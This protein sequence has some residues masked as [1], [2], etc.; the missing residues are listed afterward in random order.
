MFGPVDLLNLLASALVSFI[1]V[2][3]AYRAREQFVK[4]SI[5]VLLYLH[6]LIQ[7][8]FALRQEFVSDLLPFPGEAM[9]LI[10]GIVI[11]GLAV[12]LLT[13]RRIASQIF[14]RVT[15][16][17]IGYIHGAMPYVIVL[18]VLCLSMGMLHI[19]FV[20]PSELGLVVALVEP[21][22]SAIAREE[23]YK[24]VENAALRYGFSLQTSTLAPLCAVLVFGLLESAVRQRRLR[25]AIAWSLVLLT[26]IVLVSL[27][28]ARA[29][30]A[31]LVLSIAASIAL[32]RGL[33]VKPWWA[34]AAVALVLLP[35][36]ALTALRQGMLSGL[37]DLYVLPEYYRLIIAHRIFGPP[38]EVGLWYMQFEQV[39][40]AIG[41][42]GI[43]RLAQILGIPSANLPNQI[44]LMFT[45]T[46]ILSVSANAGFPFAFYA[47]YGLLALPLSLVA[48]W[49]LDLLLPILARLDAQLQ[50][51]TLA[52][53]ASAGLS[54][55]SSDFTVT[56]VSHGYLLL[57][58]VAV[59]LMTLRRSV[60]A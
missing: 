44:G 59:L 58:I 2:L 52:A 24:L 47:Y 9:C 18:L 27:T 13:W 34:I 21:E 3:V 5:Q 14:S 45:S 1:F 22:L 46:S 20:P 23:S 11:I 49:S 28:G 4:P 36:V 35:P 37:E 6:V 19:Y 8:P 51:P 26:L 41:S 48:L 43:P 17:G 31:L 38:L 30:A 56:L 57:P 7:W 54:F 39:F 25:A 50:L 33:S 42:S 40:G 29:F 15:S 12:S 16:T 10:H 32:R 53:M 55:I 60:C